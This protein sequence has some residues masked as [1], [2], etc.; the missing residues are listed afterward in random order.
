MRNDFNYV[1]IARNG[2]TIL[3]VR[4]CT[5]GVEGF[6]YPFFLFELILYDKINKN[7]R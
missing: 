4:R 1:N 2:V 3:R 7:L 5:D 6:G